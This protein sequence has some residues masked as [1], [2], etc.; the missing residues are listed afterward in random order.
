MWKHEV[1]QCRAERL[2]DKKEN[3][4]CTDQHNE[5]DQFEQ[6][7]IIKGNITISLYMFLLIKRL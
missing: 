7:I 3:T 6:Q 4:D 5:D 1:E 2:Q